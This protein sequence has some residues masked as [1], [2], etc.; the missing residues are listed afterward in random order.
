MYKNF[1]KP[2]TRIPEYKNKSDMSEPAL[3]RMRK[4]LGNSYETAVYY[5][6]SPISAP[7]IKKEDREKARSLF[8]ADIKVDERD[9]SKT[10][11]AEE[12]VAILRHYIE[13]NL[14]AIPQPVLIF[15]AGS[16]SEKN[17]SEKAG[18]LKLMGLE[19]IGTG[20]SIAEAILIKTAFEILKDEGYENLSLS[21]NSVGDK[22]SSNKFCREIV[23]YYRKNIGCLHAPC[24]Q[25]FKKDPFGL[26]RCRN[27]KCQK[28]KTGAPKPISYLSE[29]S[30]FHFKEVI[31]YIESLGIPYKID[32]CLI[33]DKSFSSHTLFE[34][35]DGKI[36][37]QNGDPLAIGTRYDYL[38]RKIGFKR[39]TPSIGVCMEFPRLKK[40]RSAGKLKKPLA[41][42]KVFFMQL[43]FEAKLKSLQVME[44]LRQAKIPVCQSLS[45]DRMISQCALAENMKIPYAIIMGQKEA[46]ENSVIVRNMTTRSQDTVKIADLP[47]YLKKIK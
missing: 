47:T 29:E 21:I 16:I 13:K 17:K 39:E 27:E 34:I 24:R 3:K 46:M 40:G 31:E 30:R 43:G 32:D 36:K 25:M 42:P 9:C 14:H 6:F 23:N 12:K 5:G 41:H 11:C 33:G 10:I 20:K 35:Y 44:S 18:G 37:N 19:I 15:W 8:D 2:K 28:I 1:Q 38:A 22:E 4:E 26:L 7:E 45:R